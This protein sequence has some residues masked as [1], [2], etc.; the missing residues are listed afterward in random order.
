MAGNTRSLVKS[1]DSVPAPQYYN[2]TTDT[3]EYLN[4]SSGAPFAIIY[5]ADG[6]TP[7]S[8]TNK[9]PVDISGQQV[10]AQL[11]GS[12]IQSGDGIPTTA[13]GL[14]RQ[15]VTNQTV[16]AGTTFSAPIQDYR[17]YKSVGW[18]IRIDLVYDLDFQPAMSLNGTSSFAISISTN[19]T[20]SG[21]GNARYQGSNQSGFDIYP[22]SYGRP[23]ITN[24]QT[25]DATLTIW[26]VAK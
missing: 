13:D 20:A 1:Q 6:K 23:R 5:G 8:I 25:T 4:G 21:L 19:N 26:E 15:I 22:M 3:Y 11:M 12:N 9:F 14:L 24:N 17:K 16:M 10:N 18:I 7:I 2:P